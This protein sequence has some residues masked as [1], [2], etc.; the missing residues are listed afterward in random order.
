MKTLNKEVF[1]QAP[2]PMITNFLQYRC[3]NQSQ[4]IVRKVVICVQYCY[5]SRQAYPS[6]R[7]SPCRLR[8]RKLRP[9]RL[10]GPAYVIG[11]ADRVGRHSIEAIPQPEDELTSE[12][13]SA[14]LNSPLFQSNTAG[15]PAATAKLSNSSRDG[16]V[17]LGDTLGSSKEQSNSVRDAPSPR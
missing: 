9:S 15:T 1:P 16:P 8:A 4:I 6:Q 7:Q 14:D 11:M 10:L 2:S 12:S 13:R 3:S 17:S 5:N